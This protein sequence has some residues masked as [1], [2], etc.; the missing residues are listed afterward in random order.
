[1]W[2]VVRS[3]VFNAWMA[4]LRDQAAHKAIEARLIRLELGLDGDRRMLGGGLEELRV[5]IGPGYRLYL[6]RR[7]G[8]VVIVLCAGAKGSQERDIRR[9]REI[10]KEFPL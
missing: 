4:Q 8:M 1:M 5:H 2:T 6:T 10:A 9:A 3:E 7:S